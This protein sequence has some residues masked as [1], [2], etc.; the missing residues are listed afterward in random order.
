MRRAPR[1]GGGDREVASD[2]RA[3]QARERGGSHSRR[4]VDRVGE[5]SGVQ[6]RRRREAQRLDGRFAQLRA[7]PPEQA[8]HRIRVAALELGHELERGARAEAQAVLGEHREERALADPAVEHR[9]DHL[10]GSF[11]EGP[12]AGVVGEP[13]QGLG[14]PEPGRAR[15]RPRSGRPCR[16]S[17]GRASRRRCRRRG[18]CGWWTRPG[19][20]GSGAPPRWRRA[21]CPR[22]AASAPDAGACGSSGGLREPKEPPRSGACPAPHGVALA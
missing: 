2:R 13:C 7:P 22:C 15:G 17:T 16:R 19:S 11:R 18:R 10:R 20:R 12:A 5:G 21:G 9:L 3:E 8:L 6:Q 14:L 4:R 1:G